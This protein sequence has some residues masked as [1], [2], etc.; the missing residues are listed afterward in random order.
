[1]TRPTFQFS[2]QSMTWFFAIGAVMLA[3]NIRSTVTTGDIF[4]SIMLNPGESN[5]RDTITI[6]RGFP[7]RYLQYT[8]YVDHHSAAAVIDNGWTRSSHIR[9]ITPVH[10]MLVNILCGLAVALLGSWGLP[11]L[12]SLIGLWRIRSPSTNKTLNQSGG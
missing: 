9:S 12:L 1:M 5:M 6:E 8:E 4:L 3:V 10:L 11:R 7:L 2:L